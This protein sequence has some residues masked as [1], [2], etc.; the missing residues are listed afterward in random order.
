MRL[1]TENVEFITT[2]GNKNIL[3]IENYEEVF[4]DV[5]EISING[6]KFVSEKIGEYDKNPIVKIPVEINGIKKDYPFILHEGKFQI[7]F[8]EKNELIQEYV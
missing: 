8:N 1:F 7:V 3:Q 5:Y 4:F 2:T 6:N